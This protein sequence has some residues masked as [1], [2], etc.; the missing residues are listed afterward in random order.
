MIRRPADR[1]FLLITQVDHAAFAGYLAAHLSND[2]FTAPSAD[3]IAAAGAHD[4]GWPLHD[5]QPQLNAAGQP[6]HVF[7]ITMPLATRI[8]SASAERAIPL[9]PR[10]ALLVSLHQFALSDVA[11]KRHDPKPHERANTQRD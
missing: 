7:E 3:M 2:R 10:A 1:D 6:L 8:W 5:D 11:S 9:G 4:A